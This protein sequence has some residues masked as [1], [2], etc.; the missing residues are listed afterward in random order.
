MRVLEILQAVCTVI[1]LILGG[2]ML[3][4]HLIDALTKL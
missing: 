1:I 2:S 3:T 4:Y